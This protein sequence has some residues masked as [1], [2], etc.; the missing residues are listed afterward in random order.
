MSTS[1]VNAPTV[2]VTPTTT[3]AP[4]NRSGIVDATTSALS[5]NDLLKIILP[6]IIVPVAVVLILVIAS[7]IGWKLYR[8]WRIR[9]ALDPVINPKDTLEVVTVL[10]NDK[11]NDE[12]MQTLLAEVKLLKS[13]FFEG[14]RFE[15][16]VIAKRLEHE[17]FNAEFSNLNPSF[18]FAELLELFSKPSFYHAKGYQLQSIVRVTHV[19][20]VL[21][22]IEKLRDRN[23][24][25]SGE[26]K[27][28]LQTLQELKHAVRGGHN[29]DLKFHLD[30][31]IQSILVFKNTEKELLKIAESI[32]DV[33]R[34]GALLVRFKQELD[35]LPKDYYTPILK[36]L[37]ISLT[38]HESMYESAFVLSEI[39]SLNKE[40]NWHNWYFYT[41]TVVS[42]IQR[43][44]DDYLRKVVLCGQNNSETVLIEGLHSLQSLTRFSLLMSNKEN[45]W[46]RL[47][48]VTDVYNTL[49]STEHPY[50]SDSCIIVLLDSW[51]DE[52]SELVLVQYNEIFEKLAH[53]K[54]VDLWKNYQ[55]T[56]EH[57]VDTKMKSMKVTSKEY[58]ELRGFRLE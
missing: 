28:I 16:D 14:N 35:V 38:Y 39:L 12:H 32:G 6:V 20:S 42:I 15:V 8:K 57:E 40:P 23:L 52:T 27:S 41:N 34:P 33:Q 55:I 56:R 31:L 53:S 58:L 4:V 5:V 30:C 29:I 47:R 11:Q 1:N 26:I 45:S 46:I 43:T 24:F 37:T 25:V 7:L 17:A 22:M 18:I 49:V 51:L 21:A 36:S 50:V 9:N 44:K 19:F 2:T 10:A 3:G 48:A 54:F 13:S